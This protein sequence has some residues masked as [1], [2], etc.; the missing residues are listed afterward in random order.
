MRNEDTEF[1]IYLDFLA[2]DLPRRYI[3]GIDNM[4]DMFQ[5]IYD[6]GLESPYLGK[7]PRDQLDSA[8]SSEISG[9]ENLDYCVDGLVLAVNDFD[10]QEKMGGTDKYPK[11]ARALKFPA[12]EVVTRLLG[13]TFSLGHTGALIPT[14]NLN[15]IDIAGTTVSNA[16]L[17]NIEEVERLG[18]KIGHNVIVSKRG[19]IIP[20][21]ERVHYPHDG[22][23]TTDIVFP[24]NCPYCEKPTKRVGVNVCCVNDECDER[25]V[26]R[27]VSFASKSK[28]DIM[29]LGDKSVRE[30]YRLGIHSV[31][32]LL[33]EKVSAKFLSDAL[34][35][36][37]LKIH[38]SIEKIKDKQAH[39]FVGSLGIPDLGSRRVK[40]IVLGLNISSA[41]QLL[42]LTEKDILNLPR[43]KSTLARKVV[44]GI[45]EA[46]EEIKA[47]PK[48]CTWVQN[49]KSTE[50]GSV[51]FTGKVEATINGERATRKMLTELAENNGYDVASGV[52]S[53]V[54]YLVQADP[55]S[56]STKT[57]KAN[58]LGVKIISDVEFLQSIGVSE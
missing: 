9:R 37:G 51:V 23:E 3:P 48:E 39:E 17:C 1:A 31:K 20:K 24:T 26:R 56:Q 47:I 35:E 16:L 54:T 5:K 25:R 43:F 52:S 57:K 38:K 19:D 22:C 34:G 14:G 55:T 49:S 33:S 18:I 42:N 41:E 2:F 12:E 21:I 44:K 46:K 58:K 28:M 6:L 50:K 13:V 53:S 15:P 29:H 4:H 36:N 10:M 11:W 32:D 27:L 7:I 45:E 40:E 8:Y 30:I